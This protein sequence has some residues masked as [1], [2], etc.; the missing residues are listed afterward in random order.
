MFNPV[1]CKICGIT[2]SEDAHVAV[3]AGADALG[4]NF[5]PHSPR[6]LDVERAAELCADVKHTGVTRIGLFVDASADHVHSVLARCDLDMLQFH[7]EEAPE[8]CAEFGLPYVKALRM[9]AQTDVA[10]EAQRYDQA[11]AL[12]LD[13]YVAGQPGGTGQRVDPDLWPAEIGAKLILAGGLTPDNVGDAIRR[14]RPFGV[15][16]SGG[17]EGAQKGRK[18]PALVSSFLQEV[19][20]VGAHRQ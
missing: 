4:F 3:A 16:V 13:A 10:A 12:L 9:R 14:M 18:D 1:W 15:D 5:Y 7:G 11:W 8:F 19:K 2:N 20:Y 6:V 17:V